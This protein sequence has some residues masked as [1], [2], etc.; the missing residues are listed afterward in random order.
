MSDLLLAPPAQLLLTTLFVLPLQVQQASSQC[1]TLTLKGTMAMVEDEAVEKFWNTPELAEQLLPCLSARDVLNLVRVGLLNI[2]ILQKLVVWNKLIKRNFPPAAQP[3][4]GVLMTR[5]DSLVDILKMMENHQPCL[6][7]TLDLICSRFPSSSDSS[8]VVT[9]S[10]PNNDTKL[11]SPDGFTLLEEVEGALGSTEH[12]IERIHIIHFTNEVERR[13]LPALS[14]RMARQ[15]QLVQLVEIAYIAVSRGEET[16]DQFAKVVE[17]CSTMRVIS[18]GVSAPLKDWSKLRRSLCSPQVSLFCFETARSAILEQLGGV[19][20][21]GKAPAK[22]EDL[23]AIWDVTERIWIVYTWIDDDREGDTYFYKNQDIGDGDW[24]RF[25]HLM[26]MSKEEIDAWGDWCCN[27]WLVH[28]RL[29]FHEADEEDE[30]FEEDGME[31][32]N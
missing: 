13:W 2:K 30:E 4:F 6:L 11:L 10:C 25:E 3:I 29:G 32:E 12:K 24:G 23:R 27:K 28:E 19:A 8:S 5:V 18:V 21:E 31:E 1:P 17:N 20:Q 9:L 26:D 16:L 14:A 7:A 15:Q 22:K